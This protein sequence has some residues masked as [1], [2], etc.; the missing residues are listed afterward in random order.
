MGNSL[1][2]DELTIDGASPGVWLLDKLPFTWQ[3]SDA[4][5]SKKA[6]DIQARKKLTKDTLST[7]TT[8]NRSTPSIPSDIVKYPSRANAVHI[9]NKQSFQ[10]LQTGELQALR[11]E[12]KT[13]TQVLDIQS[14]CTRFALLRKSGPLPDQKTNTRDFQVYAVVIS[15]FNFELKPR[16]LLSEQHIQG[17]TEGAFRRVFR[18]HLTFDDI[19][20]TRLEQSGA[21][22]SS[23][24][25]DFLM[26]LTESPSISSASSSTVS[27]KGKNAITK[28]E[29]LI[30]AY[31]VMEMYGAGVFHSPLALVTNCYSIL[32]DDPKDILDLGTSL[33][34]TGKP[35]LIAISKS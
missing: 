21:S 8:T 7:P 18:L 24:S 6:S 10:M 25:D 15:A 30:E 22:G 35:R 19:D 20:D 5:K 33:W 14:L 29:D 2:S 11:Q 32:T 16:C 4:L 3:S 1:T 28:I 26:D 27:T 13:E 23:M 31:E 17:T 12:G 34:K 9:S